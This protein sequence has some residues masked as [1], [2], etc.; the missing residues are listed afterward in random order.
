M[1]E[2]EEQLAEHCRSIASTM[3]PASDT[4]SEVS[5]D[6]AL[7]YGEAILVEQMLPGQEMT[8]AVMPPG[9]YWLPWPQLA[10]RPSQSLGSVDNYHGDPGTQR[11]AAWT[12]SWWWM[13]PASPAAVQPQ[14]T[15][16][17][18]GLSPRAYAE[19]LK[20]VQAAGSEEEGIRAVLDAINRD[21]QR[22]K[23]EHGGGS[24]ELVGITADAAAAL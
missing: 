16:V 21:E 22:V 9:L 4:G 7:R 1:L 14:N 6:R 24:V 3:L 23:T 11:P 15:K 13:H 2:T 5:D 17:L 20:A 10:P 18:A 12:D 8:I 19:A